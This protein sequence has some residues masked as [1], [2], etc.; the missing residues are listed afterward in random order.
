MWGIDASKSILTLRCRLSTLGSAESGHLEP[1]RK[2][3]LVTE[4][5]HFDHVT[6]RYR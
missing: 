2:I 6:I 4:D 3:Y 1:L 5:L